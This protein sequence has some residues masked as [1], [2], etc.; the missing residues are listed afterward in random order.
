MSATDADAAEPP[1]RGAAA[2]TKDQDART[3][4]RLRL[5]VGVIGVLLPLALPAG[6]W[7]AARLDG[8]SG[9][10]A[11]P[12]SMSGAYHTS[13]RDVFVGALCALGIFLIVYRFDRSN[14]ILGTVAGTCAL[15]VALFPTAPGSGGDA[16]QQT[17]SV[18]HQV[19][20]VALLTAMAAFCLSMYRAPGIADRPYARRPYLVAGVLI[21]VFM[22]LAA[23]AAVTEVGDDWPV[24]PLYLCEWLSVWSFGFAW[25]G[26]ALALAADIDRLP[27]TRAFV[28]AV[29]G[30]LRFLGG[31]G[32]WTG[33]GLR[34]GSR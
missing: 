9:A 28:G 27:R 13:T 23:V 4:M 24:T 7:I 25:T 26:A 22:A 16:G 17:V 1:R 33:G 8:R 5:G 15:G 3:V 20:A 6:N 14:D 10:D 12:G 31:L 19:F 18:F 34:P 11:W 29:L 32:A 2:R 21:L 30:R